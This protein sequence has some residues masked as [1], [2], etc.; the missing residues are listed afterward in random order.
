MFLSLVRPERISSPITRMAAVTAGCIVLSFI[1]LLAR[2]VWRDAQLAIVQDGLARDHAMTVTA[3]RAE[4]A[5]PPL[6][7]IAYAPLDI[8]SERAADG[9]LLIRSATPLA[10]H[11]PSLARLFRA[12]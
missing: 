12:A 1:A 5:K 7:P 6:R 9:S 4:P 11:D 2:L 3:R 8:R 10:P